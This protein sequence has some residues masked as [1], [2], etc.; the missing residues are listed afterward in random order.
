MT[1]NA[2]RC[3]CFPLAL[4]HEHGVRIA[5]FMGGKH[6]TYNMALWDRDFAASAGIADLDALIAAIRAGPGPMFWR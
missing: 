2:G 3:C 6:A 5:A 4:K 1:P